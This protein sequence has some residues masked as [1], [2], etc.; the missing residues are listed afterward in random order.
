MPSD[1]LTE[2]QDPQTQKDPDWEALLAYLPEDWEKEART[3]GAFT[4][5][6]GFA[7][8]EVLL[9]TLFLHLAQG[10]SLRETSARAKRGKLAQVSD[11]AILNR[12]RASESWLRY[13][14]LALAKRRFTDFQERK[15]FRKY[16]VC[17]VDATAVSE[18]GS[19]GTDWRL[20]YLLDLATL[21][22]GHFE[23]TDVRTGESFKRFPV[24]P[25]DLF[26]ADR[27]YE[28]VEGIAHIKEGGGEVLLRI[29]VA[30]C[31]LYTP[32]GERFDPLDR[33]AGLKEGQSGEWPVVMRGSKGGTVS[34]R[35]CVYRRNASEVEAAL[36]RIRRR[37]SRKGQ[38]TR[39]ETLEAAKY[40][41][42][43]TTV[44][45]AEMSL[46]EVF[47]LYRFRWQIEMSFKRLKSLTGF[48]H[49]PKY[50]GRSCRAWLYGKL[51]LGLL[52]ESMVRVPFSPC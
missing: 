43:F 3:Q 29:R 31:P 50:D 35:V 1:S 28:S 52:A 48:G 36:E 20:H 12:L 11:V 25:D 19:T 47:A 30:A 13:M 51:L 17:A 10:C 24:Q 33:C 7:N 32:S 9:R 6:R 42:I 38:A 14:A 5:A 45:E 8:P 39:E 23:L 16:R 26:L 37:E 18:P 15:A 46:G 2:S 22:C 4:R 44:P 34:G 41:A 27:G 21:T 49:L 40:V